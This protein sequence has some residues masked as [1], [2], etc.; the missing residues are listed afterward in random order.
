MSYQVK[1][2]TKTIQAVQAWESQ[3]HTYTS[4]VA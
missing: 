3:T 2:K 1:T 4:L